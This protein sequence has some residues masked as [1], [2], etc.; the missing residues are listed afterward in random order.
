MSYIY[1]AMG[2]ILQQLYEFLDSFGMGNYAVAILLFTVLVNVVFLPLSVKQ[3]KST[4]KQA[5]LRPKLE[6]LKEK[7]K[8]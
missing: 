1:R 2:W 4:A 6:A 5:S 8:H 7:A 3:Q